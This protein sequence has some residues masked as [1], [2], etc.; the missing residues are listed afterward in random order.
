MG[1]YLRMLFGRKENTEGREKFWF[2]ND[3]LVVGV[4]KWEM[5]DTWRRAQGE[6]WWDETLMLYLT[7]KDYLMALQKQAISQDL[8]SSV[9]SAESGTCLCLATLEKKALLSSKWGQENGV[10]QSCYGCPGG[11]GS[12][13]GWLQAA[14]R[15][16][17]AVDPWAE[18]CLQAEGALRYM[19]HQTVV[20]LLCIVTVD[21]SGTEGT[22]EDN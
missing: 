13:L 22:W 4:S 19:R 5:S 15:C 11:M 1:I 7:G 17:S 2:Q 18:Q 21:M 14:G 6:M 10:V 3:L 8:H 9:M 16:Q 20:E 12:F